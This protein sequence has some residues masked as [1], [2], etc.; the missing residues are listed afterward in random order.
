MIRGCVFSNKVYATDV[1]S[2]MFKP[3]EMDY[4]NLLDEDLYERVSLGDI[5]TYFND[6]EDLIRWCRD[7][8]YEYEILNNE[9]S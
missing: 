8:E 9:N 2:W 6:K 3:S 5:V 4:D 1:S 7:N